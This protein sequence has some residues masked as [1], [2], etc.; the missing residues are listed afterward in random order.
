[1]RDA[2]YRFSDDVRSMTRAIALRMVHAGAVATSPE[3]LAAW[4]ARTDDLRD[5]LTNGGYGSKFTADDLFPL[6]QANVEKAKAARQPSPDTGQ[7]KWK[8]IVVI[9]AVVAAIIGAIVA[10]AI[11][12]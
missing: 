4:I 10:I 3:E 5:K 8:R 9:V 1:M 11:A 6:F 7:A 2:R 12:S